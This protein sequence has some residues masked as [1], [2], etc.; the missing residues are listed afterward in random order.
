MIARAAPTLVQPGGVEP[1][2]LAAERVDEHAG[3]RDLGAGVAGA[4]LGCTTSP[5]GVDAPGHAVARNP[6]V[7][8]SAGTHRRERSE[9]NRAIPQP[10]LSEPA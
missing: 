1:L 4:R 7:S 10:P 3:I 2:G 5:S 6:I 8:T 9:R